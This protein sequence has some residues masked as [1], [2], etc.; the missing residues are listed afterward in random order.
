MHPKGSPQWRSRG[1]IPHFDAGSV[2]QSI[3]FRLFDS[4]SPEQIYR[5]SIE[6][7]RLT[8]EQRKSQEVFMLDSCLDQGEGAKWL[9]QPKIADL[10]QRAMLFFDGERYDLHGWVVMPNHVHALFTPKKA[11]GLAEIVGGWKSYTA[12]EA[13][14]ILGRKGPFWQKEYYDRVVRN[15]RHFDRVKDYIENNPVKAGLCKTPQ[16][17]KY[18]SAGR[19]TPVWIVPPYLQID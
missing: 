18:T 15:P 9:M 2:P 13:N 4:L 7:G 8:P 19:Q 5:W 1:Y 14:K 17:W 12:K 6:Q 10:V 11:D 16:E 3:T